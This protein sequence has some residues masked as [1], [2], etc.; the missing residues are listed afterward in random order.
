MWL[1]SYVP[2]IHN[3]TVLLGNNCKASLG[4]HA[5][6]RQRE[7]LTIWQGL[8]WGGG[9]GMGGGGARGP[10]GVICQPNLIIIVSISVHKKAL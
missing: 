7:L 3:V 9:G 10:L 5:Y 8:F 6:T 2:C 1:A 4:T